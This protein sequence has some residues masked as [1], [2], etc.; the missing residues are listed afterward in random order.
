MV[1]LYGL[2][3]LTGC[4]CIGEQNST[5]LLPDIEASWHTTA[6]I[7]P[8]KLSQSPVQHV[9]SHSA[10]SEASLIAFQLGLGGI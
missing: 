1:V 2:V 3:T 8:L 10:C 5:E 6:F 4:V 7:H 9:H